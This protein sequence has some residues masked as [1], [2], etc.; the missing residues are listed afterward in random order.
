MKKLI[1]IDTIIKYSLFALIL[2]LPLRELLAIPFGNNIKLISDTIIILMFLIGLLFK[3]LKYNINK[4]DILFVLFLIIG[5][6]T[7]FIN[8]YSLYTYLIQVRS[9]SI[10]YFLYFTLRNYKFKNDQILL[11]T[12]TIKVLA[13]IMFILSIIEIIFNKMLL[14]PEIWATSIQY[15]DNFK[16]SYGLFNNPNTYA[17]FS[18]FS[19]I[20]LAKF[21]KKNNYIVNIMILSS[22]MLTMSRSTIIFLV[23]YLLYTLIFKAEKKLLFIKKILI[24]TSISIISVI[25]I[26]FFHDKL[27]YENSRQNTSDDPVVD[28]NDKNH[29]DDYNVLDRFGEF[30]SNEIIEDS[31]YN[32]R[33]YS[34]L[35]GLEIFKEYPIIG[36]G[37]GS[38][39]SSASLTTGSK[40]YDKYDINEQFYADND[41]IKV[42]VETGLVGFIIYA[43]ICFTILKN[44]R[45]SWC[46]CL[47][48][49]GY[50][51]FLNNFETQALCLLFYLILLLDNKPKKI[52]QNEVAIYALHLNYG[53]VERNITNLA[54][55][56]SNIYNVTIYSVYNL[57]TPAFKLNKNV[58]VKYLT[59]NIKPNGKEFKDALNNKKI[60]KSFF[61]GLKSLK[62]LY[63]KHTSLCKSL[64]NC[65]S[66][67]IISTRID[68][69]QK[70]I[71]Y[72]A[73]NNI[74]ISHEHIYHNNNL[75]YLNELR[76]V[77]KHVDYLMP[78]SRYLSEYYKSL[79]PEYSDK[80]IQNKMPID[81]KGKP[82]KLDK[83]NIISVGRLSAE[84]G[85][86]DLIKVFKKVNEKHSDWTLTIAG[87]GDEREKIEELI[88]KY[89]LQDK[90][91]LLGRVNYDQLMKC[92]E[93]SSIYVMPSHEESFG[94]VLIEAANY[95]LPLIA[96][97]SALGAEE[98]IGD[99][100]ILIDNRDLNKMAEE[101][102][103]IIED[104]N[105]RKKL[106]E[107]SKLIAKKYNY[108]EVEKELINFYQNIEKQNI[109]T[110]LYKNSLKDC[111]DLIQE[112]LKNNEKKFIIT[113]NPETYILSTEDTEMKEI[114]NN[115]DNLIVP[116]GISIIKTA[117]LL[118]I[119]LKERITGVDL[120]EYLLKLANKEK[121]S[122]YLFGSSEEVIKTLEKKVIKKYPNIKLLGTTNG[123]V[124]NK[125]EIMNKIKQ[126]NPDI[127]L[128]AL[129]IP[130]QEKLIN[131]HIKD[132][133]KGVFIGVGGS[134]DVISGCK[135]RAPK[136]FIK[137]NLEWLYRILSEPKR[138]K[139]FIKYN[140]KFLRVI[141]RER[142]K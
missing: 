56:L 88:K 13:I 98:I 17:I 30:G 84:K 128:V 18:L 130:H 4:L 37:F 133:N 36:T 68:F 49:F 47:I 22:I 103:K 46:I 139:R 73:F 35:T 29:D 85:Y 48:F 102:N 140:L 80:I 3:K 72:N 69:T 41:Y 59:N 53:G 89:K 40:I 126:K 127:V 104:N 43:L 42:L 78:S 39:G 34:V 55:I 109:Y 8:G 122:L 11:I 71:K 129:G 16:R 67:I 14:F 1:N 28:L 124:D 99:N 58:K 74:K 50:G 132:F 52:K 75:T 107:K 6:L 23:L 90:V 111:H 137:L 97:R 77:L 114:V 12:K 15:A 54:N 135:K 83:K 66:E 26:N 63:L 142:H 93:E 121:Y 24:I 27:N 51:L 94:L 91:K 86:L 45:K 115:K 25:G 108:K 10:Y 96:F 31:K 32:G 131:K 123:Y 141:N 112:K 20:F 136:I 65:N 100:G 64:T 82:N 5:A 120:C 134:F 76:K 62:I 79:Y 105:Y 117:N 33:I 21:D 92:Y 44:N 138:I 57:G 61:I 81:I 106:G 19:F 116:D 113:A 110:N 70:L 119:K 95:N 101:I 118:G 125:D 60:I 9:I 38:Y 87:D 7:T 2:F